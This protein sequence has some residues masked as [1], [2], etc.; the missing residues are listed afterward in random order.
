MPPADL[1]EAKS[2][3][4][5]TINAEEHAYTTGLLP[6]QA[7][8]KLI[9]QDR[10]S[11][12][13]PIT[14]EQIQPASLDLRL[15]EIAHRVQASFL[16]G[17]LSTVEDRIRDLR[18]TVADVLSL[19]AAGQSRETI[20]EEYPYLENADIDAALTFAARQ[21]DLDLGFSLRTEVNAEGHDRE[22]LLLRLAQ[23]LA[24]FFAMEQQLARPQR[25]VVHDIAVAIRR[26][27]AIVQN[28]FL[29]IHTGITVT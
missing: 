26:D 8:R 13:P 4:A 21:A 27:V 18:M 23:E 9:E 6:S 7:I 15:G 5:D 25:I 19:L 20:L 22:S 28:H 17:Q 1:K 3:A 10:I 12:S 16:P 11:A 24:D 2:T 14:E 29:M